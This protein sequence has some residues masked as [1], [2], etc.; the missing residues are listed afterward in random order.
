MDVRSDRYFYL[1]RSAVGC[2][3]EPDHGEGVRGFIAVLLV[4]DVR[5]PGGLGG[6]GDDVSGLDSLKAR[7]CL[8]AQAFCILHPAC[9]WSLSYF[10]L[11]KVSLTAL[12]FGKS[13]GVGVCS[14][15]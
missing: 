5:D 9:G 13:F 4:P 15:Y 6:T 14:L 7:A 8:K 3:L 12:K 1:R 2:D 11:P 10:S